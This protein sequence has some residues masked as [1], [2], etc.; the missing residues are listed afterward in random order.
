MRD[1]TH[2][3][4]PSTHTP[5]T[6]FRVDARS[7]DLHVHHASMC[8]TSLPGVRTC[9]CLHLSHGW[10]PDS[11]C[12]LGSVKGDTGVEVEGRGFGG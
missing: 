8:G 11:T 3:H 9:I 5:R 12:V 7:F 10:M 6:I 2:D 4:Y 1:V